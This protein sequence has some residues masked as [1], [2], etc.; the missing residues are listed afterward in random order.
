MTKKDQFLAL[1][2]Q[3][4]MYLAMTLTLT[5]VQISFAGSIKIPKWKFA[6]IPMADKQEL[7]V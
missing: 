7:A 4:A 5:N 1:Y 2:V 3:L 6:A